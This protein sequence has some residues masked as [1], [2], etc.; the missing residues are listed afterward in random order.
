MTPS[1]PS[2]SAGG[3]VWGGDATDKGFMNVQVEE[4]GHT[5]CTEPRC[6]QSLALGG[7]RWTFVSVRCRPKADIAVG[8]PNVSF[9][10]FKP[11]GWL[12]P[13][14]ILKMNLIFCNRFACAFCPSLISCDAHQRYLSTPEI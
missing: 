4:E 6:Y 11:N 9:T 1:A 7:P 14:I 3:A 5:D 12:L 10:C 13:Y 8:L 2:A